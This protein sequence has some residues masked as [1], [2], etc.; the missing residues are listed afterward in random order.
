MK[1]FN[2]YSSPKGK[3]GAVK[4]GWC[5]PAF[6]FGSF[7]SLCSGFFLA[8][9]IMLPIELIL[10]VASNGL[11]R[12]RDAGEMPE[13]IAM[14]VLVITVIGLGI[15]LVYG[16]KGNTWR[17]ARYLRQGCELRGTVSAASKADAIG[18]CGTFD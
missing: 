7:W 3:L 12:G 5:W 16:A 1:E 18:Q 8:A 4:N 14:A 2:V 15:R 6:F 9:L 10:N 17:R 11:E 13:P